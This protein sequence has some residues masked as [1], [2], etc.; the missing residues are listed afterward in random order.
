MTFQCILNLPIDVKIHCFLSA[1]YLWDLQ[2]QEQIQ[3]SPGSLNMWELFG[4]SD[5]SK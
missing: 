3:S 4:T 2:I 1:W 5:F